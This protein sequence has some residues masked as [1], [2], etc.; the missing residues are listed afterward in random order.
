MAEKIRL[1]SEPEV[2]HRLD[3]LWIGETV[4]YNSPSH[5]WEISQQGKRLTIRTRW[6]NETNGATLRGEMSAEN[7]QFTVEG[8]P[9][10]IL[11][12]Q[13]FIIPGWDT[14]DM[15]GKLGPDY[16][17][18]FSRPGLAELLAHEVYQRWRET[19]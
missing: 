19:Q 16:D 18:V 12:S 4:G 8:I 10:F 9:A 7:A 6:E 15:R 13:H 3:G 5:I 2:A 1:L 14:N 17:V 11:G